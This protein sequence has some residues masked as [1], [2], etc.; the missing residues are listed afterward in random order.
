MAVV[1]LMAVG[2][3]VCFKNGKPASDEYKRYKIRS[4]SAKDDTAFMAEVPI[5][6]VFPARSSSHLSDREEINARVSAESSGYTVVR[7]IRP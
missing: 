2:S 5:S 6:Q 7:M 1:S 3:M 4:E